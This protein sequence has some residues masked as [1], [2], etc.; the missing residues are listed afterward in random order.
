M[1]FRTDAMASVGVDPAPA[2]ETGRPF[3]HAVQLAD[4]HNNPPSWVDLGLRT[5]AQ[6]PVLTSLG[7]PF[8]AQTRCV[9]V[10]RCLSILGFHLSFR[11]RPQWVTLPILSVRC[12]TV[13]KSHHA[14]YRIRLQV[15]ARDGGKWGTPVVGWL[16]CNPGAMHGPTARAG[17][18]RSARRDPCRPAG[19]RFTS[20]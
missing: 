11:R 4:C 2:F 14:R 8:C 20:G 12:R 5:V 3:L 17:I 16:P 18:E 1:A 19:R 13:P 15:T 6:L 7:C 9:S 10:R